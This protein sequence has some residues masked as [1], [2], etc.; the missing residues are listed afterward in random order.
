MIGLDTNV[1]VRAATDDDPKRSPRARSFLS[2]L[3]SA[4]PGV[5]NSVVL[6]EFA[7]TLKSGY[8]YSRIEIADAIERMLRSP[9]YRVLDREAVSVALHICRDEGLDFAD[10]LLGEINRLSGCETTVT[11]DER[12]SRG[13]AFHALA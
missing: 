6:A 3:S 10:A 4:R 13:S 11:F 9:S 2:R 1:L 12:A 5:V 8:G 7:W